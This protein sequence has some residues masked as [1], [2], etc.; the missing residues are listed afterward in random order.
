MYY[1]TA[2]AK[3]DLPHVSNLP[4]LTTHNCRS[5]KAIDLKFGQYSEHQHS[6]MDGNFMCYYVS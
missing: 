3:R 5:E 1:V 2:F 6:I 4:T